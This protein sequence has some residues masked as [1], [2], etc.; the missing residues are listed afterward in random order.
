MGAG[1]EH[2]ALAR[3]APLQVLELLAVERVDRAPVERG[4]VEPIL[5]ARHAVLVVEQHACTSSAASCT[6]HSWA[7]RAPIGCIALKPGSADRRP[8]ARRRSPRSADRSRTCSPRA[9]EH[10]IVA[11]PGERRAVRGIAREDVVQDRRARARQADDD[12]RLMH[13][14]ARDLGVSAARRDEPE[15]IAQHAQRARPARSCGRAR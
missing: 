6:T 14:D 9:A 7:S 1:L 4:I 11:L 2:P 3:V 12:D 15:P 13:R 5:V 8:R 10:G